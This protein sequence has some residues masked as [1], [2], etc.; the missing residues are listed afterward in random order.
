MYRKKSSGSLQTTIFVIVSLSLI[1]FCIVFFSTFLASTNTILLTI[2]EDFLGDQRGVIEGVLASEE[3]RALK[4]TATM[5]IWDETVRFVMGANQHYMQRNWASTNILDAYEFNLAAIKDR[6]GYDH[7]FELY[8][9]INNKQIPQPPE[10]SSFLNEI[11]EATISEFMDLKETERSSYKGKSG[12]VFFEQVPYFIAVSPI[13]VTGRHAEPLGTFTLGTILNNDFFRYV[14]HLET[15]DFE[16]QPTGTAGDMSA[17]QRTGSDSVTTVLQMSDFFGD[18]IALFMSGNRS[19]YTDGQQMLRTTLLTLLM[20]VLVFVLGLY[21]AVFRWVLRPIVRL[22]EDFSDGEVI[23]ELDVTKYS[24]SSEF[25]TLCAS[26]NEM[27]RRNN[28][29]NVSISVMTSILSSMD[30]QIY[31][32]DSDTNELLFV[33]GE[34]QSDQEDTEFDGLHCWEMLYPGQTARCERCPIDRLKLNPQAVIIGEEYFEETGR[35]YRNT[36]RFIEWADKKSVHML[37]RVDITD[38]KNAEESLRKRFQQEKLMSE[39][40]QSFISTNKVDVLLAEALRMTGDFLDAS[41]VLILTVDKKSTQI[42]VVYNWLADE[43]STATR[44][45]TCTPGSEIYEAFFTRHESHLAIDDISEYASLQGLYDTGVRSLI[46]VPIYIGGE[47]WGL[48]SVFIAKRVLN[49]SESDIHLL[50][51][52]SSVISGVFRQKDTEVDLL[53]MSSIVD[54]SPQFISFLGLDASIQYANNGIWTTLGY[55][56]EELIRNGIELFLSPESC[57]VFR[58]DI[59]HR[60]VAEGALEFEMPVIAKDGSERLMSVLAFI[61]DRDSMGIGA[62]ATDITESRRMER[63]LLAA[64]EEAEES[65][66]A[67]GDFLSRMSHEM[68][69]PMNAIIGMTSIAKNS[70]EL[71][72]KDY[73]LRKIDEASSHLLGVINDILDMSKIEANKLELMNEEFELEGMLRRA[74]GVIGFRIDEKEQDFI[75][76]LDPKSPLTIISDEQHLTQVLTNLL[77]NAAKFTP[78]HGLIRLIVTP[79]REYE[80]NTV[81]LRFSVTDTGIGMSEEQLGRLFTSFEQADGSISRRFGGTGL[82]LAISRG[83]VQLMGGSIWAESSLG[84]GSRFTFTV[85]VAKGE[86][87]SGV[88][89]KLANIQGL[90]LLVANNSP[91]LL[92]YFADFAEASGLHCETVSNGH[93]TLERLRSTSYEGFDLVFADWKLPDFAGIDLTRIIRYEFP[94]M[95][96]VLTIS[97]AEWGENQAAATAA[98]VSGFLQKPLFT[99]LIADCINRCLDSESDGEELGV[100]GAVKAD[101]RG[102]SILIAEDVDINREIIGALL[103]STGVSID[104]TEDGA[105]AIRAFEQNSEKYSLIFMDI[106]M[107]EVDGFEAT[108]RIRASG[109]SRAAEVPIVAM[110]ANVFREDIE[111]CLAAGMNGHVGKPIDIDEVLEIMSNYLK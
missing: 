102:K 38:L 98:G 109:L 16:L 81:N 76:S 67:K 90:R 33:S 101:F 68:R 96:V 70:D 43:N 36:N 88:Q 10:L 32:F 84:V 14:T 75:V 37:Q 86:G 12:V 30:G 21:I 3:R 63:E 15:H 105:G 74:A 5:S 53:R 60:I 11:S 40:S 49:W 95:P 22:S 45:F 89:S 110:T 104:F 97:T 8:D 73:C 17:L 78:E 59:I 85:R 57:R 27:L 26:I 80:D 56:D 46:C 83:I 39:L 71:A 111:K 52:I 69:T 44:S 94:L 13:Y 82:G 19:T 7:Y 28:E 1:I 58:T 42:N 106:H 77:S 93:D 20:L 72:Q 62:M 23:G 79:E 51:M 2:E 87:D 34:L 92:E 35:Y 41:Q 108:R 91:E 6:D 100:S 55:T 54:A 4:Q 66:R 31:L 64:K 99:S 107:P 25:T 9:Y 18:S 61:I 48:F 103:E 47:L 65:S 24:Q 29:S 50:T